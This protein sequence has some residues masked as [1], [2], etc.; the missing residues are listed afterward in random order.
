MNPSQWRIF[1]GLFGPSLPTA[2][3]MELLM[4]YG[5]GVDNV[6]DIGVMEEV[7]DMDGDGGGWY[8]CGVEDRAWLLKW[9]VGTKE[10]E[11]LEILTI[12]L[13]YKPSLNGFWTKV[14]NIFHRVFKQ[15]RKGFLQSCMLEV[16]YYLDMYFY[17]FSKISIKFVMDVFAKRLAI[18]SPRNVR[19]LRLQISQE[20]EKW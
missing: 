18:Q 19:V 6:F 9:G 4:W 7:V 20:P 16:Q 1:Y 10:G 11:D 8:G 17:K 14:F 12:I 3:W 13:S 2:I 5:Q 15:K